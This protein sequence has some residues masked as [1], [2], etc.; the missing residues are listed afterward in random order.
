[1]DKRRLDFL[2]LSPALPMCASLAQIAPWGVHP[3]RHGGMGCYVFCPR[4][5]MRPP[6]T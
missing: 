6:I 2:D 4:F 5:A 3:D 1:L